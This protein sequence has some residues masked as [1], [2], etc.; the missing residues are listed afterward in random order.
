MGWDWRTLT[1]P[2]RTNRGV[3][4]RF[5]TDRHADPGEHEMA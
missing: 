2:I 1:L 4:A 5:G 3:A